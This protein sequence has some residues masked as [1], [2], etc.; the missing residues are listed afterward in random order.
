MFGTTE[1]DKL[2][3]HKLR[4]ILLGKWP[5]LIKNTS[6]KKSQRST[7]HLFMFMETMKSRQLNAKCDTGLDTGSENKSYIE[8]L[9][10]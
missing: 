2:V 8:P 7:G 1:V 5:M 3:F 6:V 4:N 10:N 9:E